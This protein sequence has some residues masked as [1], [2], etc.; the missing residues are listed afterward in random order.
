MLICHSSSIGTMG[1]TIIG[2]AGITMEGTVAM[3]GRLRRMALTIVQLD[4]SSS[5]HYSGHQRHP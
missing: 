5:N 3:A 2:T 1:S 4:A